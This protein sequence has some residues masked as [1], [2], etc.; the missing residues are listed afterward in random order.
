MSY[1]E[2]PRF[3]RVV[4]WSVNAPDDKHHHPDLLPEQEAR[5]QLQHALKD[6]TVDGVLEPITIANAARFG[7]FRR[8]ESRFIVPMGSGQ[9]VSKTERVYNATFDG[10]FFHSQLEAEGFLQELDI[11]LQN[12]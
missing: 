11:D 5:S 2:V 3:W 8:G 6:L 9:N 10:S 12:L 7:I 1:Q 4:T